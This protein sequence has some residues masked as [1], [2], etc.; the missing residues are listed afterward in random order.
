MATAVLRVLA[1]PELLCSNRG[2]K[3]T[4]LDEQ[5]PSRNSPGGAKRVAVNKKQHMV[6]K[7]EGGLE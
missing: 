3:K 2:E 6:A 5:P 7:E 1:R 4:W